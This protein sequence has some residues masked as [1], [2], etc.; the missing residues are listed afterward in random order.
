MTAAETIG[1]ALAMSVGMQIRMLIV[2]DEESIASAIKRF[3]EFQ[4]YRVD[5]ARELEEAIALLEN[6]PYQVVVSDLRLTAAHGAEGLEILSHVRRH[7]P[8]TLT[9]M[10]TAQ[11]GTEIEAEARERGVNRF[12]R[13]PC[14]L[15]DLSHD[16][17]GLLR[18]A[19]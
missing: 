10:L 3:F 6:C 12:Y 1:N 17:V 15:Q 5:W 18:E 16:I 8:S 9:V 13:K 19:Q 14:A 2:D 7:C 11:G 4:G